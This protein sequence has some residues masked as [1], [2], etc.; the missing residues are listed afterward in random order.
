MFMSLKFLKTVMK[1]G[2]K[3]LSSVYVGDVVHCVVI[4]KPSVTGFKGRMT[5]WKILW[6]IYLSKRK[7]FYVQSIFNTLFAVEEN[8]ISK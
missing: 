3:W 5:D 1:S 2:M 7:Y 8:T 4:L 6:Y